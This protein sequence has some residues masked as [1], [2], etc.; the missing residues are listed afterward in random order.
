[1][2]LGK[3]GVEAARSL[4]V[5]D[6]LLAAIFRPRDLTE[7]KMRYGRTLPPWVSGGAIRDSNLLP[8]RTGL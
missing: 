1:M 5:I 3:A 2:S 8:R 6:R 4:V 7:P